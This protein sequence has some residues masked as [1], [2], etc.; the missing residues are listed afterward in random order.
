MKTMKLN[1]HMN[2]AES[3]IAEKLEQMAHTL[4]VNSRELCTGIGRTMAKSCIICNHRDV[5]QINA[6]LAAGQAIPEVSLKY[7]GHH[8]MLNALRR[9][10]RSHLYK[11]EGM[12]KGG[13]LP[14]RVRKEWWNQRTRKP[15][16]HQGNTPWHDAMEDFVVATEPVRIK[17][18]VYSAGTEIPES[19][20]NPSYL[21][22]ALRLGTVR[23]K[24]SWNVTDGTDPFSIFPPK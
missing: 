23:R 16:R 5:I 6:D 19:A 1:C 10:K 3:F 11:L 15:S 21:A 20:W 7:F 17:G 4:L 18:V 24:T 8:R 13:V 22:V 12:S 2:L 14:N 9:H